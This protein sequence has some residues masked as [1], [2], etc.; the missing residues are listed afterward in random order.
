M[1]VCVCVCVCVCDLLIIISVRVV[2]Q[3]SENIEFLEMCVRKK[4]IP[5]QVK[6]W[7][8]RLKS[9]ML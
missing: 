3:F 7:Q 8:Q 5:V 4:K 2:M 6:L 1:C 9:A